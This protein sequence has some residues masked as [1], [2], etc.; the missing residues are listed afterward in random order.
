MRA[1]LSSRHASTTTQLSSPDSWHCPPAVTAATHSRRAGAP[2]P[3]AA[4]ALASSAIQPAISPSRSASRLRL[5]ASPAADARRARLAPKLPLPPPS[6]SGAAACGCACC[7]CGRL[8]LLA[9]PRLLLLVMLPRRPAAELATELVRLSRLPV[10]SRP[11]PSG[12][13]AAADDDLLLL[14]L[15]CC[16]IPWHGRSA[17]FAA[18]ACTIAAAAVAA[19]A[20]IA[21]VEPGWLGEAGELGCCNRHGSHLLPCCCRACHLPR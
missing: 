10:R 7:C 12:P 5:T 4:S 16:C 1:A 9:R 2:S 13:A 18:A 17:A 14:L 21:A 6:A 19:A 20:C 15:R 3:A 8:T 11:S